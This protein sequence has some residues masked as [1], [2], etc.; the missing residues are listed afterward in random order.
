MKYI[1]EIRAAVGGQD[2][3]LFTQ[4]LGEAYIRMC[5]INN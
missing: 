4:D 1:I 3:K 2:A 5:Q